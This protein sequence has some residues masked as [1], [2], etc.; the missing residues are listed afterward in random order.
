[1]TNPFIR[2]LFLC[3]LLLPAAPAIAAD[4]SPSDEET[5]IIT[6]HRQPV[7]LRQVGGSVSV[8]TAADLEAQGILYVEDAL[9]RLPGVAVTASGGPGGQS[10]VRL[11][12]EEGYRTL[13]LIDG[14]RVSDPAGPQV[15]VNFT[16]LTVAAIDR[17]EV[18]RG[19]QALLYGADAIGGVINI[20]TR[21]GDETAASLS[22]EGGSFDTYTA[23]GFVAGH[24]NGVQGALGGSFTRGEGFSAAEGD[25]TLRDNDGYRNFTLHGTVGIDLGPNTRA[26]FVGRYVDVAA[27]FDGFSF[28][29]DRTLLTEEW[30]ARAALTTTGAYG[31]THTVAYNFFQIRRDDLDGG[32]PTTDFFGNPIGRFDGDRHEVEYL[33]TLAPVNGHGL[34]FGAEYESDAVTT[35]A[36]NASTSTLAVFAEWQAEWTGNFFTTLGGRFDAPEDFGDHVSLRATA[37]WLPDLFAGQETKLRASAGTGFR[38]P[39]LY[40][41]ATNAAASLP[42]LEEETAIGFDIGV[43]QEVLGGRGHLAVTYFDQRIE[44][45]I[46]FDNVFFTGYFQ[47][48]GTSH[49]RGVAIEGEVQILSNLTISSQY[50]YTDAT[51]N[52]PD[53]ED[54]LPRVRRPRHITSTDID[55]EAFRGRLRLNVNLRTAAQAEDGFRE[56]RN[57]LDD[58]AVVGGAATLD[59]ANGVELTARA[60]NVF[61][62]DYQEVTGFQSTGRSGSIGIRVQF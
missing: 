13:V 53:A 3:S 10:T 52:S 37:A 59:L 50:T 27:Q 6:S 5:F 15:A 44:D 48:S 41:Q 14:I 42:A 16:T 24:G 33:G 21:R 49:S 7:P 38:A 25:P 57:D 56:F 34:T 18:L 9:R 28:D 40:E 39:S 35:D 58:Y 2:R 45:E 11:R 43:E 17:I 32:A 61:D 30:A 23:Q 8:V 20:I 60:T 54:G 4:P 12:G 1:M 55:Y 22:A 47:A 26:A 31:L 36:I 19:P 51:V 29:P 46:R 62:E